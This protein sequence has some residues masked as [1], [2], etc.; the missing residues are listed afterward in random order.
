VEAAAIK[1][2]FAI[3]G[4][5]N[6]PFMEMFCICGYKFVSLVICF[7]MFILAGTWP[8]YIAL[9][10]TGLTMGVFMIKTLKRYTHFNIHSNFATQGSLS[11]STLLYIVGGLQIPLLLLIG[12]N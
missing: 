8:Y 6:A 10:I 9:G 7:L 4:V 1:L 12:Y 2:I 3:Q 5:Q 11:K